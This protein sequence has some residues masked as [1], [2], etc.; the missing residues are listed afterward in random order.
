[1]K[2]AITLLVFIATGFL[3]G[4]IFFTCRR[5]CRGI[6]RASIASS[7]RFYED[8]MRAFGVPNVKQ[9]QETQE[10][11]VP[12]P[13]GDK[14]RI[15]ARISEDRAMLR[16][17]LST[18]LGYPISEAAVDRCMAVLTNCVEEHDFTN[19]DPANLRAHFMGVLAYLPLML[20]IEFPKGR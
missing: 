14:E 12:P 5:T 17:E 11:C 19:Y 13:K 20:K 16:Q 9:G 2:I 4:L 18:K 7:D 8:Q 10:F 15:L 1:M 6:Y 3:L